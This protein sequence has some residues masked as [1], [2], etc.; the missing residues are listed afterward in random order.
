MI[1]KYVLPALAIIG[2]GIAVAMVIRGNRT[3]P[4]AQPVI[5]PANVPFK[6]YLFGPGIVEASTEN[7]AIGTPASGIVTAVYVKWGDLVKS[8]TPLFKVDARD[9]EAQLL[10]AN[11][12]VKEME[13]QLSPANAK[14]SEAEATLAKA[15]NRLR[16][17]E[18]LE[19]GVSISAEEMAN[20]RLDVSTNKAILASAEAQIDQIKAQ[21]ASAKAQVEQIKREIDLRTIRAPVSGRILQMKTRPGEYAQSGALSTP[22][23]LLGDDTRLHVRVDVDEND[24]WRFQPC[25][26]ALATVRGNPNIKTPLQYVRTDPDVIP[27]VTLTGDTTQRTDTRV[28]QVIYGFDPASPP[29][30]VGQLMDVFIEAPPA[31]GLQGLQG[32]Q[33]AAGP[34][35]E[36]PSGNRKPD[37]VSRRKP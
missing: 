28:L 7:I 14:V 13:A 36:P 29:L 32:P 8:G 22:L 16:I 34:C 5:Q 37:G 19:T 6:S 10:P 25:A 3:E 17:G 12:K 33:R 27:R 15:Q 18:G 31:G 2:A 4:A 26:S 20:R 23:M 1:R 21:I 11:A 30:Y 9:L 24:A 35:G